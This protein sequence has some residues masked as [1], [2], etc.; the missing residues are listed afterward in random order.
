MTI[1][2][3]WSRTQGEDRRILQ[4]LL[5]SSEAA[6]LAQWFKDKQVAEVQEFSADLE[7]VDD[8]VGFAIELTSFGGDKRDGN[9][10]EKLLRD[11]GGCE[12]HS[13]N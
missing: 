7:Q 2:R 1:V 11:R 13:T 5:I 12:D 6:E 3:I 9:A 4:R 8:F 10:F